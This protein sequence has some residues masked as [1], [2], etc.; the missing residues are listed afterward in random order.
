M[1]IAEKISISTASRGYLVVQLAGKFAF[2]VG[3]YVAQDFI[4]DGL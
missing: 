3:A 4:G 2:G 1:M